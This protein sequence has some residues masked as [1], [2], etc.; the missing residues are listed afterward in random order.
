MVELK[1]IYDYSF[2]DHSCPGHIERPERLKAIF[3]ALKDNKVDYEP[4]I[5][6]EDKVLNLLKLAHKEEYISVI[7]QLFDLAKERN[8]CIFIDADTYISPGTKE[9][10]LK[11]VLASVKAAEEDYL[12]AAVRPPGHHAGKEGR[13]NTISQG[14]CIFNNA[15]IAA[16]YL[17]NKGKKVA[18]VDIDLHHGNGTED[19]VLG[20]K[21]II[22]ISL[23]AKDIYPLTGYESKENAYNFPLPIDTDD[24]EWKNA[25]LLA[26]EILEEFSPDKVIVSLGFDAHKDD[27]L[28]VF[29]VTLDS[30]AYAFEKLKPFNPTYILE[31]GYNTKVL[32][33]GA[34]LLFETYKE[35]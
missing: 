25:F 27:P 22:Y 24:E 20:D 21:R 5:L 1:V 28:S 13:V 6:E 2:L 11:A 8:E 9:A 15:A 17:A 3:K 31:G 4:I 16:K 7:F 12:F 30:Y 18:I 29:R 19:I 14:F 23:H 35:R 32:Y 10:A 33:A 34:T 26:L